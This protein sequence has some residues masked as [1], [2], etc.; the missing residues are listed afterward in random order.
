M[1]IVWVILTAIVTS[2]A[3]SVAMEVYFQRRASENIGEHEQ[4]DGP[5]PGHRAS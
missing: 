2:V 1:T 3:T 5:G 4:L